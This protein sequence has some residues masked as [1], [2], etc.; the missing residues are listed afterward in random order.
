MIRSMKKHLIIGIILIIGI[1]VI[2]YLIYDKNNININ[3][4]NN[5]SSTISSLK[6]KSNLLERDIIVQ[7]IKPSKEKKI[8]VNLSKEFNKEE[9]ELILEYELE[10]GEKEELVL[11]GYRKGSS[12]KD[13]KTTIEED[14][15]GKIYTSTIEKK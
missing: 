6:I 11:F 2:Y 14:D 10:N 4:L 12:F 13:I 15:N 8:K 9:E 3:I 7:K 5:T 1:S